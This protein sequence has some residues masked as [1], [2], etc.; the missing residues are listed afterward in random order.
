MDAF[1]SEV[2]RYASS[3]RAIRKRNSARAANATTVS[4]DEE[5]STLTPSTRDKRKCLRR[6]SY[7]GEQRDELA[8]QRSNYIRSLTKVQLAAEPVALHT[9][10][11]LRVK[12]RR[13]QPEHILS[14][15]PPIATVGRTS[16]V[17]S[18]VPGTDSCIAAN[19]IR[20]SIIPSAT[21]SSPGGKVRLSNFAACRLIMNSN[22]VARPTGRS[23]GFSPLRMRP[24]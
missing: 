5:W 10:G 20:Y 23:A 16:Q 15:L 6:Q 1:R 11:L 21:A 14:A 12:L 3:I 17:G 13:T 9:R 2:G 24:T 22:L 7:A 8:L 19:R 18:F 4:T